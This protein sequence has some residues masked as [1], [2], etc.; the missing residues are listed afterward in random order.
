[1]SVWYRPIITMNTT[2]RTSTVLDIMIRT[3]RYGITTGMNIGTIS[4]TIDTIDTTEIVE[5]ITT[6]IDINNAGGGSG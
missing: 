5:I 2:I 3:A 4:A 1:M 6:D